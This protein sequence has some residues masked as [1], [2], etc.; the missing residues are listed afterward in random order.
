MIFIETISY[1]NF[2]STFMHYQPSDDP[3]E[4]NMELRWLYNRNK[5]VF[6]K[7]MDEE[8]KTLVREW[9]SAKV[10]NN[11][12]FELN[13]FSFFSSFFFLEYFLLSQAKISIL[14]PIIINFLIFREA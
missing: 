5:E 6:E 1:I 11:L 12:F 13:Y 4:M 2:R 8:I 9:A 14:Y 3:R 10:R 7:R